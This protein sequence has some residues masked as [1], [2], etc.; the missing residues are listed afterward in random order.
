MQQFLNSLVSFA[1]SL[2]FKLLG[3]ALVLILGR[4][5]IKWVMKPFRNGKFWKRTDPT[6]ARFL[7][8]ALSIILNILLVISV[9]GILGVPL[10]SVI[11]VLAS[12]GVAIGLALQGSLS[13]LAGG[14]MILIFHPFKLGDYV[15]VSSYGGTVKDIGIFYTVL[16]T[17]DNRVV[18]IPNG[19]I[20]GTEI[21][22]Y[23]VNDTRRVDLTL[24]VAYGTDTN[25]VIEVLLNEARKQELVLDDPAPFCRLS[26]HADSSL[27]FTLR[28]WVKKDD[29]W[30]VKFNLLESINVRFEKEGIEVPYNQL[31]VHVIKED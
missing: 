13:N 25:R 30:T 3:A 23:S 16:N 29:Y 9:I 21:V 15:E 6:V 24:S 10:T 5:L 14:I 1:T 11:T 19:T 2:A 17:P 22:N 20:M 31:D 7:T 12:A 26:E 4:I 8:N 27:N 28:V 18:T